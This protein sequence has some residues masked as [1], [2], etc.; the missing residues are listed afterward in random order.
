MGGEGSGGAPLGGPKQLSVDDAEVK[1][2]A[3]FA[4]KQLAAQSNSLMPPTLKEVCV[5]SKG[6]RAQPASANN[7]FK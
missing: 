7:S 6:H 4:V 1:A 5:L 3:E 2:A